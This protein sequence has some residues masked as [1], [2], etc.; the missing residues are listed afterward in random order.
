MPKSDF[1]TTQWSIVAL[2]GRNTTGD[3]Q[4][5]L[6]QLCRSYWYPIYVYVRR[7][8]YSSHDAQD[9]TQEFFAR[10]LKNNWV[11]RADRERGRFRSFLLSAV[12][13]FLANEWQR[14][15]RQKRG[16]GPAATLPLETAEQR[17]GAEITDTLT[18][19][20]KFDR[21]WALTLLDTVLSRLGS[22]YAARGRAHVFAALKPA[23]LGD[24][25]GQTH[26][27]LAAKLGMSPGAVRV[28]IHRI[29]H[30]FRTL[31]RLEVGSTV[32]DT[33]QIEDE[34]RYLFLVLSRPA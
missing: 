25:D 18:A 1:D 3:G 20:E 28:A 9:L 34:A 21:R 29:R 23:L 7:R 14:L 4:D 31:F 10:L 17:F 12:N 16:G 11:A 22:E 15:C 5:A 33:R 6:A 19:E 8:G 27:A 13:H 26:E 30:R 24:V 2:A 32:S